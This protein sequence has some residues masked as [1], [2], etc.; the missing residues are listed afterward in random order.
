MF[1]GKV[2]IVTGGAKGI[3]KRTAEAFA[4]KECKVVIVDYDK[5]SGYKT[6]E[7]YRSNGW[8][9]QFVH[10]DVSKLDSVKAMMEKINGEYGKIDILINNA[11]IS[12]FKDIWEMTEQDWT[13]I[14]HNN[15]SSVFYCAREAARYM[16]KDGGSIVNITSTRAFQSEANTEGY[17]ATKG[18]IYS[19]THSLA[20]TLSE[21]KIRVNSISPGWIETEEYEQLREIDHLQH[22]SKRV[23]KPSDI[24]KACLYL[25]DPQNDFVTGSN[26]VVDGGMTRKMIYEH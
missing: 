19:L 13:S 17:S 3:G 26:L 6:A 20:I 7:S 5:E 14:L 23:G 4:Q 12:K 2:V 1:E 22:P 21:Y 9:V 11:G 8:D 10:C 25:A 18:G 24:A 16:K 15:L